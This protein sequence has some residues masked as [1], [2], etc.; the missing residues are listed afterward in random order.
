MGVTIKPT[1]VPRLRAAVQ[2][3]EQQRRT[4]GAASTPAG[5]IEESFWAFI[6]GMTFEQVVSPSAS[7]SVPLN[8]YS[9]VRVQPCTEAEADILVG[10]TTGYRLTDPVVGHIH[11]A[12]EVNGNG[13]PVNTIVRMTFTGYRKIDDVTKAM[14]AFAYTPTVVQSFLPIHDH[15]DNANG[16]MS[17]SCYHPGTALPQQPWSI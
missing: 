17:F 13:T 16:G 14:Y 11:A 1:S 3:V 7:P 8:L 4:R 12:V 15:R 2:W 9:F 6:T 5:P 10:G